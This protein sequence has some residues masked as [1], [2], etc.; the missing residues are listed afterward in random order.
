[1]TLVAAIVDEAFPEVEADNASVFG[2]S[3]EAAYCRGGFHEATELLI[4]AVEVEDRV[5]RCD[6]C[7]AEWSPCAWE[8]EYAF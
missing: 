2:E 8:S 1:M 7:R 4:D 6:R 3:I 5:Y